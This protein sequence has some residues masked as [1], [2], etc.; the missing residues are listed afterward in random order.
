MFFYMPKKLIFFISFFLLVQQGYSQL[1]NFSLVLTPTSETCSGNGSIQFGISGTQPA[2]TIV[3]EVFLLPNLTT[4]IAVTTTNFINGLVAGNYSV[5]ATQTLG[6]NSGFQQQDVTVLNAI[7][8]LTYQLTGENQYCINDGSI[9]VNV[10]SGNA[11]S[12]EIFA[13]PIIRPLQTSNFFDQLTAGQY[14]VRV[15]DIC[16]EGVVQTFTIVDVSTDFSLSGFDNQIASCTTSNF[17]F[18]VKKVGNSVIKYPLNV[19][20]TITPSGQSPIQFTQTITSGSTSVI[21]ISQLISVPANTNFNYTVSVTNGCNET[22]TASGLLPFSTYTGSFNYFPTSC[23]L[24]QIDWISVQSVTLTNASVATGLSLPYQ[25][26]LDSQTGFFSL[27]DM[28]VG[29]YSFTVV[30]LCNNPRNF[31]FTLP[32]IDLGS[33]LSYEFFNCFDFE[34]YVINASSAVLT[35]TSVTN[36]P[37]PLPYTLPIHPDYGIPYLP[38]NQQGIYNFLVTNTCT[39]E[40]ETVSIN[41]VSGDFDLEQNTNCPNTIIGE[42]DLQQVFLVSAPA[43]YPNNLPFDYSNTIDSNGVFIIS[44]LAPGTYTFNLIDNCNNNA[45]KSITLVSE[46]NNLTEIIQNCGSFD[47]DLNYET[48]PVSYYN[49]FLQRFDTATNQW[50]HPITGISSPI[51]GTINA[52][53]LQNFSTNYNFAAYGHFRIVATSPNCFILVK[54]FDFLEAPEI[55]NVFSIAC[56]D[57]TFDVIVEAVGVP[58]LQYRIVEKDGLPFMIQNG[59]QSVFLG[60]DEAQY[61]FQVEDACGNILNRE[62]YIPN[63]FSFGLTASTFCQDED[64]FLSVPFVEVFTY[65]WWKNNDESTV[66]ST[67]NILNFTSFNDVTDAGV[68]HINVKYDHPDSCID[69]TLEYQILSS[70]N[71]PNAGI[72]TTVSV[73]STQG[74]VDLFQLLQGTYTLGGIWE[75]LSNTNALIGNFWNS[76]Q[77]NTG[78]YNFKY[79]VNGNCNSF[80]ESYLIIQ[81]NETPEAPQITVDN[82]VCEGENIQFFASAIPNVTYEWTG[83]SNFYST[84][85]NPIINTVSTA[86]SGVYFLKTIGTN[87]ESELVETTLNVAIIPQFEI[88]RACINDVAILTAVPLNN[89]FNIDEVTYN[90]SNANGSM[91]TSNSITIANEPLG[92]YFLTVTNAFNCESSKEIYVPSTTCSIPKGISA[93]GD[94]VNDSFDL[95]GLNVENLKIFS[96]YGREVYSKEKYKKEWHGQDYNGKMLPA[97]TYYYYIRLA[98]GVE[99]TGWVYLI[100]D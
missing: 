27:F 82:Q 11:S 73:C 38:S 46:I 83:P 51:I 12:Y 41:V 28:P 56:D 76:S 8:P 29:Q 71:S 30:D 62:F 60:L 99:K 81:I 52:I 58:P 89:S 47:I 13:G 2:A 22:Q 61:K 1:S 64:A 34:I 53:L 96:R 90:W 77:V 4:P 54:E 3:Y 50:V 67:T 35:S 75:D 42:S 78:T 9:T 88:V 17:S 85:Q 66:L 32:E 7:T 37:L 45:T 57:N 79:R 97:A 69:F 5:I 21:S 33:G 49:Y 74:V 91:G 43:S 98:D 95:S 48:I 31:F 16:G 20:I 65:K 86:N 14:S 44:G 24:Y 63:P 40:E 39:S 18:N 70:S 55:E 93:N 6:G 23:G 15:F 68:Y 59:T 92:T 87:C 100:T 72:D 26:P 10:T 25:V 94:D 36:F 84:D 19:V 80:D